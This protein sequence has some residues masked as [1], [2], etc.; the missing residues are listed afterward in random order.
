MIFDGFW[1]PFGSPLGVIFG[2]FGV[3]LRVEKR[4]L[5]KKRKKGPIPHLRG[6]P[7]GMRGSPGEPF[8]GVKTLQKGEEQE[9]AEQKR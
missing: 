8:G 3:I 5:K 9:E 1:L 7:G 4:S 2:T 6:P